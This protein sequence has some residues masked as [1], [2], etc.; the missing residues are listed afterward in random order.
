MWSKRRS[1]LRK[2]FFGLLEAG[3]DLHT[4]DDDS[5]SQSIPAEAILTEY[6]AA[7][8]SRQF[9]GGT[10]ESPELL[11]WWSEEINAELAVA[12]DIFRSTLPIPDRPGRHPTYPFPSRSG[13]GGEWCRPLR[14]TR[15]T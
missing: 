2:G 6:L 11:A 1:G 13:R 3:A 4:C 8:L 10:W 12:L 5:R 7:V 15:G 9:S 14:C